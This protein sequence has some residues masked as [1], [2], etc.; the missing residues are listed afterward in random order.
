M[1]FLEILY[2]DIEFLEE[3][4]SGS[5]GSVFRANWKS[6]EKVV[7]VKKFGS[8]GK[9]HIHEVMLLDI[10]LILRI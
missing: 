6:E 10:S 3:C 4:G 1:P 9:D 2:E 7:A 8:L 5:F